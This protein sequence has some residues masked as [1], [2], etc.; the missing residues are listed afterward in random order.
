[1]K[2]NIGKGIFFAKIIRFRLRQQRTHSERVFFGKKTV[3]QM[4]A[5]GMEERRIHPVPHEGN[6]FFDAVDHFFHVFALGFLICGAAAL[7]NGQVFR[8]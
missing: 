8:I 1:M 3:E 7:A 5:L 4:I 2:G 6:V